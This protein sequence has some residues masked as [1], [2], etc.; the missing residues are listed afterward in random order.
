M[1]F[2]SLLC[3]R[4]NWKSI[5]F[6]YD[7][8]NVFNGNIFPLPL[9]FENDYASSSRSPFSS[10]TR[11][12]SLACFMNKNTTHNFSA[13]SFVFSARTREKK[14]GKAFDRT[15]FLPEASSTRRR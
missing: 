3:L 14:S 9:C 5:S 13:Q 8:H 7:Y 1:A 10:F 11:K 2:V 6:A 12:I 4:F 15:S